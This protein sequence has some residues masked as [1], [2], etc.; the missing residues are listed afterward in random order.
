MEVTRYGE[1]E[2]LGVVDEEAV[3]E[4]RF[5]GARGTGDDQERGWNCFKREGLEDF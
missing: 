2:F 1:A 4:G 3:E 5:S